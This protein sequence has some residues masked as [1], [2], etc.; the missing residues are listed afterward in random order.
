MKAI[1]VSAYGPLDNLQSRDVPRPSN[2]EGDDLL[3]K[4]EACSVNPIDIK[5]RSGVYDD[6]PDYYQVAPKGFHIIGYDGA[7]TV[8]EVGPE[9]QFFKP[10]DEISWVGAPTR[11][12]S[13][14]EYQLVSQ[15][16]CSHKANSLDFVEAARF[17]LTFGTAYQ[18]LYYRLEIKPKENAGILIAS[19]YHSRWSISTSQCLPVL[20]SHVD[21]LFRSIE[22][23][24]WEALLFSLRGM[25]YNFPW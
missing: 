2:P 18:S 6:A 7:G 16:F 3:V 14:A 22:V 4:V 19:R 9:C 25:S 20:D 12:G 17:G 8:L 15:V 11:Q 13:Y 23:V 10:G 1:G 21:M 5:I 24:E